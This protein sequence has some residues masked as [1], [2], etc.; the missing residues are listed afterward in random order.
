MRHLREEFAKSEPELKQETAE[1]LL[2]RFANWADDYFM[3]HAVMSYGASYEGPTVTLEGGIE[4]LLGRSETASA[5]GPDQFISNS[6]PI[7]RPL[8]Q[9]GPPVFQGPD[10]GFVQIGKPPKQW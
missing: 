6:V 9:T 3:T 1:Q 8:G 5:G 10:P 4:L 7:T 2:E